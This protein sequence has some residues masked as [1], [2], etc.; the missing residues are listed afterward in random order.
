MKV[1]WLIN[2]PI[3]QVAK[4]AGLK[5][6]PFGGWLVQLADKM[7]D[8]ED[9]HLYI[10]FK[11]TEKENSVIGEVGKIKYC[12]F[13]QNVFETDRFSDAQKKQ[14]DE[15]IQEYNPDVVQIFGT[16]HLHSYE[17]IQV[18]KE[19]KILDRVVVTIQGMIS[20]YALHYYADIPWW[21]R[22]G[23][24]IRD[25]M[26]GNVHAGKRQFEKK[27][28]YEEAVI[29]EAKNVIGRTDWDEACARRLNPNVRYFHNNETLRKSFYEARWEYGKCRKH[30]IFCSQAGY[31]IKGLH[32][33]LDAFSEIKKEYEDA[34]L[35]IAGED[36]RKKS[37]LKQTLYQKF[38]LRKMKRAGLMEAVV[39]TGQLAEKDMRDAYLNTNVFVCPS[40]I[41][42]SPNS[43]GE[44]MLLG[45]PVVT[46][47]VGGVKNMLQHEEGYIYQH[48]ATY[49]LAYYV[50]KV[51]REGNDVYEMTERAH[52]HA[53]LTHN[54]DKNAA[55]LYEIY[56]KIGEEKC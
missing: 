28:V 7:S 32:Y 46:A 48:D 30:S 47:D 8:Y 35:Y 54:A 53:Q 50:K 14:F 44:A 20:I 23:F 22:Y 38:L 36:F 39:F 31:P 55:E 52:K 10:V 37:E 12:G 34:T 56:K 2:V 1:I 6:V 16:E 29:K 17:M 18:C 51:F 24:S 3:P 21:V 45:V 26:R 41:E 15:I 4:A 19:H 27:G 40:S 43:V 33:M 13:Y 11:Q 5:E 25:L 42:N 49:M 9:V